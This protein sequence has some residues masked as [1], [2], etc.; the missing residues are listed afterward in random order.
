MNLNIPV[1][2]QSAEYQRNLIKSARTNLW[3]AVAFTVLNVGMLLTGSSRYFLFSMTMPYYLTFFGYLFDYFTVG[4]YTLTGLTLAV[5]PVI[6]MALC[7]YMSKRSNR[8]LLG[9]AVVFAL[10]T[11]AMLG[12][13]LWSGDA[14]SMLLDIV[15]HGWVMICLIRG[16]QADGRLRALEARAVQMEYAPAQADCG[17]DQPIWPED[18]REASPEA[19]E[20]PVDT[21]CPV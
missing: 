13:M 10:D 7:A 14:G 4:T 21:D 6:A 20:P 8:W 9:A 19:E 2:K 17:G 12:L 16:I 1:D 18:I 15:F 3:V 11:A 5:V